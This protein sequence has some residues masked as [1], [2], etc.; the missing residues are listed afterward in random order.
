MVSVIRNYYG[1]MDVL[2]IY[3]CMWY[4][5]DVRFQAITVSTV[6][7]AAQYCIGTIHHEKKDGY[8]AF[9]INAIK[10]KPM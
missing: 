10:P 3:S 7:S 4:M 6:A 5:R 9:T 1:M 2:R 8:Q